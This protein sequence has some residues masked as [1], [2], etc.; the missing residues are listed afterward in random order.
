MA[1]RQTGHE[2]HR[3]SRDLGCRCRDHCRV[4]EHLQGFSLAPPPQSIGCL[5]GHV[6]RDGS[7]SEDVFAVT[8]TNL[9]DRPATVTHIGGYLDRRYK[10]KWLDRLVARCVK[11]STKAFLFSFN[12]Y[13]GPSLPYK[14]DPWN[15]ATFA[16]K[17]PPDQFPTIETLEVTTAD[18]RTWFCPRRDIRRIHADETYKKVHH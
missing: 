1:A 7:P 2:G 14:L 6:R 16:Y 11:P 8:V 5:S 10:P 13:R 17:I 4:L 15:K 9:S 3:L 12:S 18:D